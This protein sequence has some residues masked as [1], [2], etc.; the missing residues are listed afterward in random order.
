MHSVPLHLVGELCAGAWVK[1]AVFTDSLGT[2]LRWIKEW[3]LVWI[4]IGPVGSTH[5]V[6]RVPGFLSS[7][8]I[9]LFGSK[10]GGTHSLAGER[11]EGA[12]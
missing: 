10:G 9:P 1:F 4:R 3:V 5:R 8:L 12:N 11:A 6:Y 7:R 2:I